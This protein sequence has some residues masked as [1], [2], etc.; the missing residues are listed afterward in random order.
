MFTSKISVR[1]SRPLDEVF[2]YVADAPNRRQSRY[3]PQT[4]HNARAEKTSCS[5]NGLFKPWT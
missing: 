4:H 1:I 5:R 3:S 2:I